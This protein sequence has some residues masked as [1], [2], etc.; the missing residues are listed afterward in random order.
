[1]RRS[2]LIM[3]IIELSK[4]LRVILVRIS[5]TAIVGVIGDT[6]RVCVD[7]ELLT[8]SYKVFS[9][10]FLTTCWTDEL[11]GRVE[12]IHTRCDGS[13]GWREEK[14]N[15]KNTQSRLKVLIIDPT[16]LIGQ[17]DSSKERKIMQTYR[18]GCVAIVSLDR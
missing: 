6:Q 13:E 9:V 10:L 12:S 4:D 16:P 3:R 18:C 15:E 2:F 7:V 1:M 5:L 11:E 14:I 17:S 8:R